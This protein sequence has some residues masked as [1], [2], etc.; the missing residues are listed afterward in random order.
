MSLI[1]ALILDVDGVL[2]GGKK[3]I[4]WPEPNPLVIK[5][6]HKLRQAGII[7]SLCTGK[8]TFAIKNIVM[9]AKL[10]NIHIGDGG[11]VVIDFINY[12]I[13]AEYNVDKKLAHRLIKTYL[14]NGHY[15][16][17]YTIDNYF[18]QKNQISEITPKHAAILG[19]E[20]ILV[21]SLLTLCN[22]SKIV[23][24]MPIAKDLKAKLEQTKLFSQFQQSLSLQWGTHP[25]TSSYYFGIITAPN[26]SKTYAAKLISRFYHIP[27][28]HI[29]GVGDGMTDWQFIKLCKYKAAMGNASQELKDIILGQDQKYAY[30]GKSVNENGI[31]DILEHFGVI[32]KK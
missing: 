20:P 14:A 23:K 31:I 9:S 21:D 18:V 12:K 32:E 7:V 11:A 24:I 17:I 29:L 25:S 16:E 13:V 4:N 5:Y 15:T 1:K 26:I 8:G 3:G 19:R 2:V 28:S 22:K 30:I 10:N 6:L 27:F